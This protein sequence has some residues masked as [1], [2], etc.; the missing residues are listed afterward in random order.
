M[1]VVKK[2]KVKVSGNHERNVAHVARVDRVTVDGAHE[3]SIVVV[4]PNGG[5]H[6]AKVQVFVVV[7]SVSVTASTDK[8]NP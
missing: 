8:S 3:T 1:G 2:G 7:H 5:E 4:A 6:R